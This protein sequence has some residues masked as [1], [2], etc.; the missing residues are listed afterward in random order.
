MLEQVAKHGGFNLDL[1]ANGDVEVDDHHLIEDT[2]IAL[3]E[4]LKE[5]LETNG[6]LIV[7]VLLCL[8]MSPLPL[9][10]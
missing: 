2:A 10:Q 1:N 6:V 7:M 5:A 9:S 8:W 4:A 3:G